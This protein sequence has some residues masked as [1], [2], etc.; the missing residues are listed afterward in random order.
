MRVT[1]EITVVY[2]PP[3]I[4]PANEMSCVYVV[5]WPFNFSLKGASV[6]GVC[7]YVCTETPYESHARLQ[8]GRSLHTFLAP[9]YVTLSGACVNNF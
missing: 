8:R 1:N 5:L 9:M 2:L 3:V 6:G 4:F 7:M